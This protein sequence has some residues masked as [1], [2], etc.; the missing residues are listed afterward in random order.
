VERKPAPAAAAPSVPPQAPAKRRT[1]RRIFAIA[2][3]LLAIAGAAVAGF[4]V[5]G[6]S[7]APVIEDTVEQQIDGLRGFLREHGP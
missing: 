3:V 4:V 2:F 6:S 5:G 1:G 7:S